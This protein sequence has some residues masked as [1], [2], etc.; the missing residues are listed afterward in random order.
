MIHT[1]TV[2]L[3][4]STAGAAVPIAA[5]MDAAALPAELSAE[6]LG[7]YL[8]HRSP[9]QQKTTEYGYSDSLVRSLKSITERSWRGRCSGMLGARNASSR[10]P[11]IG[12]CDLVTSL[13]ARQTDMVFGK[14]LGTTVLSTRSV[15]RTIA[16]VRRKTRLYRLIQSIMSMLS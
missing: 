12:I 16:V 15:R 1:L 7:R 11:L 8:S 2:A 5:G 3:I 13:S 10:V 14:N 9:L 4:L 6:A